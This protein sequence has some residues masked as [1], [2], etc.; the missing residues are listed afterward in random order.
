MITSLSGLVIDLEKEVRRLPEPRDEESAEALDPDYDKF[1][2][3][4]E[5]LAEDMSP[6]MSRFTKFP[7]R[8]VY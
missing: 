8:D 7:P 2:R 4:K 1:M 5:P 3:P 6:E